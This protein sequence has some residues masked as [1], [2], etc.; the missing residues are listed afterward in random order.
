L[1]LQGLHVLIVDDNATNRE[2]LEHQASVWN[3]RHVSCESAAKALALLREAH[4]QSDPFGLAILDMNMPEM[5]GLELARRIKADPR[6]SSTR[7]IM[8][9]S[10]DPAIETE[11]RAASG[12][13]CFLAKPVR[14]SDLFNGIA[15]AVGGTSHC[16][17]A[18]TA[19]RRPGAS[20]STAWQRLGGNVLLAEDNPVNQEV[21]LAML[22]QLGIAVTVV[23]D[24]SAALAAVQRQRFD[25]VLMDCQMPEMD[26]YAATAA[27]RDEES[28][29]GG[30]RRLPIVALTANALDGERDR[31]LAAGM[32]DYLSK[33][34]NL[35]QLAATL[36]RWLGRRAG[37][38]ELDASKQAVAANPAVEAV[39]G[40]SEHA[41]LNPGPLDAIRKLDAKGGS[42][43][44]EKVV[45][46][47]ASDVRQRVEQIAAQIAAGNP[48]GLRKSAHS[49]K[50]ASG[51][52]GAERL[53]ALF[54][55]MEDLG[56]LGSV[57][58]AA[59]LLAQVRQELPGVLA[60]LD[61]TIASSRQD[62]AV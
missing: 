31:C 36:E 60:A 59:D 40:V 18:N 17:P 54:R 10:A 48:E 37:S 22:E 5:D 26:G 34:F 41:L 29:V 20:S 53:V 56:R 61:A 57:A 1:H 28:G 62:T 11:Q 4:A 13:V 46:T 32:D 7:L 50:S 16:Q 38:P 14:Q 27:I 24:G 25:L 45:R 21:A 47:Y 12:V 58:G 33:P 9:S 15:T 2:I 23:R 51:N 49:V 35:E 42:G 19:E 3:M 52:V 39:A 55:Q 30:S 8:L 44:L 6:L 43:L